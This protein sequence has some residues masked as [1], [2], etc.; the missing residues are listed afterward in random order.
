MGW[1]ATSSLLKLR[2]S[3]VWARLISDV[4]LD[5]SSS[6]SHYGTTVMGE[7]EGGA[8]PLQHKEKEEAEDY[9]IAAS[10]EVAMSVKL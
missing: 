2:R 7:V 8:A 9:W 4:R 10:A 3:G 1:D 6:D 5:S